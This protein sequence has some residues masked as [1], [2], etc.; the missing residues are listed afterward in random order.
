MDLLLTLLILQALMGTL[1]T[2]YHHELA[3]ALPTQPSARHELQVHTLRWLLY[4]LIFA[5]LAWFT[6]GNWWVV[7]L[8]AS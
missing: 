8:G 3:A 4:G 7:L 1:D 6:F 5:G 2:I